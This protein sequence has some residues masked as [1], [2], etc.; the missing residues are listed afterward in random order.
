[1]CYLSANWPSLNLIEDYKWVRLLVKKS[2]K[3]NDAMQY[4]WRSFIYMTAFHIK[5]S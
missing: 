1:M 3:G 4:N 5:E 2:L